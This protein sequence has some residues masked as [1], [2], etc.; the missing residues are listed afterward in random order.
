MNK[1]YKRKEIIGDCTL[2]HG[3]A[4][5]IIPTLNDVDCII[6]DPP[7]K[8][9]S[10]GNTTNGMGGCF[11][12][13]QYDNSGEIIDCDIDWPDFMPLLYDILN[14]GH[15]Y[16]MC[17]NRHVA[18]MLNAAKD[19]GFNFHNLLVW[20]KHSPTP[21]RWYMKNC[22][23]IGFFYK[24]KAKF[25]NN[26]SSKQLI[27][28]PQVDITDHPTEKPVML[29]RHYIENSS[30]SGQVVLDP[31]MGSGTTGEACLESNRRFI[32]IEKN[33]QWF[34]VACERIEKAYNAPKQKE[35]L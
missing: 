19:A 28:I 29:M 3:D 33:K 21:N 10:G 32:G 35:L 16:I 31:F 23:Y 15:A 30:Q 17:N 14:H 1:A 20:D 4:L 24:G 22:E 6:T 12:H 9:T 26:C 25:I 2:Y 7:Y 11:D 5:E 27:R 13:S 18:N 34:D 8:L